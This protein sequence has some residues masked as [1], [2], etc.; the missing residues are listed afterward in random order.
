MAL[1]ALAFVHFSETRPEAPLRKFAFTPPVS[2]LDTGG[3]TN[4]SVSPNGRHVAF[5]AA[6]PQGKLWIQDLD[7]RQPRAIEGT[8]GAYL[9]FWSPGSDFIGFADGG[10]LNKVAAQDGLA[11]RLCDLHG[12]MRGATWSP[13]GDSIVFT[14]ADPYALYEV[15]ARGGAATLLISP[16]E[17]SQG[18]WGVIV[19]P[20]FLP[21]EAGA[22]VVVFAFGSARDN[23]MMVQD[24]ETGRREILGPGNGGGRGCRSP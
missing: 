12:R 14:S 18:P 11:I 1:L 10:G 3:S 23:T 19:R 8:E 7:R 6:G 5:T 15:P 9:P 22:R 4:V 24:L 13:D 21:L 2:I 20:H 16:E 17:P